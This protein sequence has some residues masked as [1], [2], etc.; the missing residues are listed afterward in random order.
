MLKNSKNTWKKKPLVIL[1]NTKIV[2][3]KIL[4]KLGK[5]ILVK[6]SLTEKALRS[7]LDFYHDDELY[8]KLIIK[9]LKE[10]R[11]YAALKVYKD[12]QSCSLTNAKKALDEIYIP[13]YY[14]PT[15]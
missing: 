7:Y 6:T 13:K 14:V 15:F 1:L 8:E 9:L 10:G 4:F 12:W 2:I 11:R 5:F 3:M